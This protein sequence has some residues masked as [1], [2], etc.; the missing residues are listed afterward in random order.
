MTDV[1]GTPEETGPE[2]A[3]R[4]VLSD[5]EAL[6]YTPENLFA[7]GGWL[8]S[9]DGP[10]RPEGITPPPP[11][12]A[13]VV[14]ARRGPFRTV[15]QAVNAAVDGAQSR[16]RVWIAVAPGVYRGVVYLP[17]DAPPITIYGT[18]ESPEQ[19]RLELT[20]DARFTPQQYQAAVNAC[21]EFQPGDP[22]WEHYQRIAASGAPE[23]GTGASAVVWA[24]SDGFQLLN[25]SVVNTLLDSVDGQAHQAV[26]LRTDGDRVQLERLRLISRQDTL[27]L[28]SRGAPQG[29]AS[30]ISRVRVKECY[31]EGDVDYVFGS[32][33][34]CFENVRFHTVS[35]RGAGEA[36]VLAPS[37]PH[38]L[39][40]GF[41]V[42]Q[43]RFTTDNGFGETLFA[44]LGRAWDHGARE[45]G[46]RPGHTANG[47]ALIR[48][49]F[50]D[51]GF[52]AKA[53]WGAAATTG[54]PFA[55]SRSALRDDVRYNRLVEYH[56]RQRVENRGKTPAQKR[57]RQG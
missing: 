20:L 12:R 11:G 46:Y 21:G 42:Q 6:R 14:D 43:C 18:G 19:V 36:F 31:I 51:A 13:W 56:N 50:T 26:A 48:D 23:I 15:Q 37:T 47:Q 7:R 3:Q 1:Q 17:A 45:T 53:P 24:Q 54:R 44:K 25:L 35:S 34:A 33:S 22:S 41:L 9:P 32:A 10:W 57:R 39:P 40:F 27:W 4:P 49:S 8:H 2:S 28:N 38:D 55:A 30:H 16:A 5:S 52:D 29:E